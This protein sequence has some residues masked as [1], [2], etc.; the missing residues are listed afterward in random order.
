MHTH[1]YL[2]QHF[3]LN[4]LKKLDFYMKNNNISGYT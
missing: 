4:I 2:Y 3:E 1:K